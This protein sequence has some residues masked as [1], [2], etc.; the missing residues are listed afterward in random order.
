MTADWAAVSGPLPAA[1]RVKSDHSMEEVELPLLDASQIL[2][3]K[4]FLY[5]L[6]NSST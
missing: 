1:S 4:H 6:R 5:S 3:Q 2:I